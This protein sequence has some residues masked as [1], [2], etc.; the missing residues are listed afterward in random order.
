MATYWPGTED[1]L[2][3]IDVP[4]ECPAT[5]RAA[6]DSALPAELVAVRHLAEFGVWADGEVS[7]PS[8]SAITVEH[9]S[10]GVSVYASGTCWAR[11]SGTPA[12]WGEHDTVLVGAASGLPRHLSADAYAQLFTELLEDGRAVIGEADLR[13][14]QRPHLYSVS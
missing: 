5:V 1:P 7:V 12:T 2:L 14:A 6:P 3:I 9:D 13:V 4:A 10:H 8:L 11:R